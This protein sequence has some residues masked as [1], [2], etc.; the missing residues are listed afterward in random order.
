MHGLHDTDPSCYMIQIHHAVFIGSPDI[1]IHVSVIYYRAQRDYIGKQGQLSLPMQRGQN[2]PI[3][4]ETD[5]CKSSY[6]SKIKKVVKTPAM[7]GRRKAICDLFLAVVPEPQ[8][9]EAPTLEEWLANR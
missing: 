4:L 8:Y 5:E 1:E 3:T 7:P 9:N 2:R 6:S